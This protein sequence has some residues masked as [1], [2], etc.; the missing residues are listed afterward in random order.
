M[1]NPIKAFETS[2]SVDMTQEICKKW[3]K[4][5]TRIDFPI[6]DIYMY[7]RRFSSEKAKC[8]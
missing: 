4:D 7:E 2:F 5:E 3:D 8:A 6:N 1:P